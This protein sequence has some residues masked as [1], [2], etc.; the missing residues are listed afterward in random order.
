MF[1]RPPTVPPVA[2]HETSAADLPDVLAALS[3]DQKVALL[4]GV[5]TWHT[6]SF[7]EPPVP[8]IRTSDGPAGVRGTSF[9][10]PASASP[11]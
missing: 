7:A 9:T 2:S 5:D 8:A 6:A 4:A 11:L 3:L 1:C 10:G